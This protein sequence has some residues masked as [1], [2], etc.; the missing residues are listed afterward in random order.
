MDNVAERIQ[1]DSPRSALRF[2][3]AVEETAEQL[4]TFPELGA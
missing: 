3:E 1:E 2:L 4:A